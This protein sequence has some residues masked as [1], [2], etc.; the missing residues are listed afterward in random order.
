M[1]SKKAISKEIAHQVAFETFEA[2]SF[3]LDDNPE[4][5]GLK[6]VS[7]LNV[8]YSGGFVSV[9]FTLFAPHTDWIMDDISDDKYLDMFEEYYAETGSNIAVDAIDVDA[10]FKKATF[11][12]WVSAP[13]IT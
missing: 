1:N 11:N 13:Y 8:S 12:I 3:G 6:G 9:S 5:Y 7:D 10:D 4:L 2:I